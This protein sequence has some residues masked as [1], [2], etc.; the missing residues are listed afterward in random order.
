VCTGMAGEGQ[1]AVARRGATRRHKKVGRCTARCT[2]LGVLG[3]R[4]VYKCLCGG[5]NH[6][7]QLHNGRTII[8]DGY[9]PLRGTQRVG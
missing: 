4:N 3:Q 9:S 6:I 8:G 7:Q 2:C 1:G 5:M